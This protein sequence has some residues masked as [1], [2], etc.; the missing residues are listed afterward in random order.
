MQRAICTTALA[1]VGCAQLGPSPVALRASVAETAPV[2][3][4]VPL[5]TQIGFA[6]SLGHLPLIRT[7]I[8]GKSHWFLIDSGASTHILAGW[9]ARDLGL[10]SLD[11]GKRSGVDH[12]GKP[13]ALRYTGGVAASVGGLG[14]VVPE[15]WPVVDLPDTFEQIGIAGFI[16]PQRLAS[17]RSDIVFDF[18]K[19]EMRVEPHVAQATSVR[20]AACE[21]SVVLHANI[22]GHA[23][24][25]LVDTGASR[26]DLL[27]SSPVAAI[28]PSR[29][30]AQ[31]FITATGPLSVL[32]TQ[33][34]QLTFGRFSTTADVATVVGRDDASCPRDGALAM[35]VL[36]NC[37]VTFSSRDVHLACAR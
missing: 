10:V 21:G 23:T 12:T 26:T 15:S 30:R 9:F 13:I 2:V 11:T 28:L 3:Q 29:G 35:D 25:L 6:D 24:R 5:A 8:A 16:S 4:I 36:R 33:S 37:R 7:T 32:G 27:T 18:P 34:A 1:L 14:D 31:A 20:T 17:E 22:N 19:R